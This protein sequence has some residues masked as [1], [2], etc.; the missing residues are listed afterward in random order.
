M[1]KKDN[2]YDDTAERIGKNLWYIKL[3]ESMIIGETSI[4]NRGVDA[5][6]EPLRLM[7]YEIEYEEW[8]KLRNK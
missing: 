4:I 7:I 1:K 6:V 8:R 3:N 2:L 5:A